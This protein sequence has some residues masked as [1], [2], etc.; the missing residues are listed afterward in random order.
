MDGL[1][2]YE[3]DIAEWIAKEF[4]DLPE[5]LVNQARA[6]YKCSVSD[7]YRYVLRE[8][9]PDVLDHIHEADDHV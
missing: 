3:A 6:I 8:P 2:A 9:E 4:G 5:D 7:W 1:R